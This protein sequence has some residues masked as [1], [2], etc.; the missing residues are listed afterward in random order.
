ML[1]SAKKYIRSIYLETGEA[2]T[3][4]LELIIRKKKE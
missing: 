2:L 4:E 1:D 3:G